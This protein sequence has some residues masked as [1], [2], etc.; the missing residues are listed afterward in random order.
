LQRF[1]NT[2]RIWRTLPYGFL[3]FLGVL[4]EKDRGEWCGIVVP[5]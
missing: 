2:I 1:W 5:M 4:E 3:F